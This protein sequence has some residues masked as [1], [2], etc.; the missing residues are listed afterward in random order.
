MRSSPI[1]TDVSIGVN[2]SSD[3]T[4]GADHWTLHN[5]DAIDLNLP[6]AINVIFFDVVHIAG[7]CPSAILWTL[8]SQ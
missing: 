7:A 5:G 3:A 8:I 2:S 1:T 4:S 6:V